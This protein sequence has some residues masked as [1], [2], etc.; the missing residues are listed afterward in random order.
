MFTEVN[1]VEYLVRDIL[2][3]A[4]WEYLPS[5]A[6]SRSTSDVLVEEHLRDTLIQS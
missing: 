3:G 6:L 4:G 2:K 5:E 1:S